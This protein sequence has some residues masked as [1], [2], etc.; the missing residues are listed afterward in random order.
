MLLPQ[1]HPQPISIALLYLLINFMQLVA[2]HDSDM[3]KI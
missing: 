3:K 1:T 2:I